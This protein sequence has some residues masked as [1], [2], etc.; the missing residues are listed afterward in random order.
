MREIRSYGSVRGVRSNPHPYRDRSK[1]AA[2][3]RR[4][5]GARFP[6]SQARIISGD[7]SFGEALVRIARGMRDGLVLASLVI[8][9]TPRLGVTLTLGGSQNDPHRGSF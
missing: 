3:Q 6:A 2:Q 5:H 7:G 1:A 8:T 9:A 4:D